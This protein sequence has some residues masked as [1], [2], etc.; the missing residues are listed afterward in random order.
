MEVR[1]IL[2]KARANVA[3]GWCQGA[4]GVNNK[5]HRL[6]ASDLSSAVAVCAVGGMYKV[7]T[8]AGMRDKT[9]QALDNAIREAWE[10]LKDANMV[11]DVAEY[12]DAMGRT[13]D[14]VLALFDHAIITAPGQD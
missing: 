13:K 11:P 5:G 7:A 4:L 3:A 8:D 10:Q 14:E 2:T 9:G 1:D 6:S 12:N